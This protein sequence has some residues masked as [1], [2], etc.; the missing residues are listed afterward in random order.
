MITRDE[1]RSIPD[2]H[3]S[4]KRD[5]EQLLFLREKATCIPSSTTD[6]ERVQSSPSNHGNKYVEEAVDLSKD[7]QKKEEELLELQKRAKEFIG[8]VEDPLAKK[9]LKLRYLKCYT[10]DEVAELTGYVVRWVQRIEWDSVKD[11]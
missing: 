9:I 6:Q 1:I 11:L 10:W 3:K 8:I 2:I 7:I 5:K 4:I